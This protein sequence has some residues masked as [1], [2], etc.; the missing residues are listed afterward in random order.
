[1]DRARHAEVLRQEE[2]LNGAIAVLTGGVVVLLLYTVPVLGFLVYNILGFLAF[3]AVMYTLLLAAKEKRAN[4]VPPPVGPTY[5][6]A[7]GPAVNGP[8]GVGGWTGVL[9]RGA[10]YAGWRWLRW[11]AGDECI[12]R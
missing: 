8:G 6:V 7:G 11:R 1:M 2:Q 9:A 3:G 5:A 12:H 4:N 10:A